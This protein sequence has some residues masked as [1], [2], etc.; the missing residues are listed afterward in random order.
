MHSNGKLKLMQSG[1]C[2]VHL[3]LI[4]LFTS[5][6]CGGT[7]PH[8]VLSIPSGRAPPQVKAVVAVSVQVLQVEV[9][10]CGIFYC[11]H[12]HGAVLTVYN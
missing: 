11:L 6:Q 9:G 1:L 2:V 10:D 5:F 12:L 7:F 4:W 8:D 3:S